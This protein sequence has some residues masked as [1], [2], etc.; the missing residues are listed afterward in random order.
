M[1]ASPIT[2]RRAQLVGPI[3]RLVCGGCCACCCP[4]SDWPAIVRIHRD[5][6][7]KA[8][9]PLL[10]QNAVPWFDP[11]GLCWV[12]DHAE[13]G[14]V[15]FAFLEFEPDEHDPTPTHGQPLL[16]DLFVD[17]AFQRLGLGRRLIAAA[18][19][20]ARACGSEHLVL[21]CLELDVAARAF[22]TK[23]G[24]SADDK[25]WEAPDGHR[26]LSGQ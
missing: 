12:A 14:V 15:G 3:E 10:G 26:H 17:P 20:H 21:G 22:Y 24:W 23:T 16:D 6:F 4:R 11:G 18:E 2:I 7:E 9:R 5:A 19:D 13:H 25:T 1:M 8:H